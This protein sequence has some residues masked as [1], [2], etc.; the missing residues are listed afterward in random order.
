MLRFEHPENGRFYYIIEQAECSAS[1]ASRS[2]VEAP[3]LRVAA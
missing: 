1:I 3:N 2:T